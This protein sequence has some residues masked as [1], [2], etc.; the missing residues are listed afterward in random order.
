MQEN[1]GRGNG[2]LER[3]NDEGITMKGERFIAQKESE[4]QQ[5]AFVRTART[6]AFPD[7]SLITWT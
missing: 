3:Q 5:A 1:V 7:R 6:R 4:N 2:S